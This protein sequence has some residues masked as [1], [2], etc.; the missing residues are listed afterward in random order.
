MSAHRDTNRNRN[1]NQCRLC[2]R[3]RNRNNAINIKR[4][5]ASNITNTRKCESINSV[6]STITLNCTSNEN[7]RRKIKINMYG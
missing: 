6:D 1:R 4:T 5:S 7:M 3:N 2:I